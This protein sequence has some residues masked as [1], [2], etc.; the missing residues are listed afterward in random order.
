MSWTLYRWTWRLVSPLFIGWTPSGALHRCRT[1]V[2]ART[3]WGALTAELARR[4]ADGEPAYREVGEDLRMNARFSYLYP[5]ERVGTE[6][7]AWLPEY[8]AGEGLCWVREGREG[9][10][11]DR[12]FRRRLLWTRSGTAI[13]PASDS[14]L[15]GSLRETE[16]LQ[17]RWRGDDGSPGGPVAMVGYVL[18]KKSGSLSERIPRITA[19]FVGGDTRYGLGRLE[20][21]ERDAQDSDTT[22]FGAAVELDLDEPRIVTDRLVAHAHANGAESL[23][24]NQEA[25]GGWDM[26]GQQTNCCISGPAWTPGSRSTCGTALAWQLLQNGMLQRAR[27]DADAGPDLSD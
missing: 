17:T 6:W 21:L 13:D 7:R 25:I 22:L 23:S 15:E 14:A 24:G 12:R 16:C 18:I 3:V 9:A 27:T 2:P 8:R 11:H 4:E 26:A 10:V 5:A 1:Y 19:L 20:R